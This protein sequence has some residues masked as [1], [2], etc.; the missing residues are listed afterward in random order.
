MANLTLFIFVCLI[1]A[2][3]GLHQDGD[4]LL[5]ELKLEMVRL[6]RH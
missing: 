2:S 4:E 6:D 3:N 5:K 1:V